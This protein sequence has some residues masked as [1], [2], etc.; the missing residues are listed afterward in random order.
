MAEAF[1][2]LINADTAAHAARHLKRVWSGFDDTA[3]LAVALPGLD[4]LEF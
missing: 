2:L 3:F 1:K 4:G